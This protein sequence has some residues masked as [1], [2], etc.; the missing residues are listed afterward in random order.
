ML[1]KQSKPTILFIKS[2]SVPQGLEIGY[3]TDEVAEHANWKDLLAWIL[4][5]AFKERTVCLLEPAEGVD[6]DLSIAELAPDVKLYQFGP[7][8]WRCAFLEGLTEE[9]CRTLA[10]SEAFFLNPIW[11]TSLG[12][13]D[14][15]R[16]KVLLKAKTQSP[17]FHPQ[18]QE[19]FLYTDP[20][21]YWLYWLNPHLSPLIILEGLQ[22]QASRLS[23]PIIKNII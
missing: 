1:A 14:L 17:Y 11:L 18:T 20:D 21:G 3:Q 4:H 16:L 19:E 12:P 22:T 23:W 2:C 5:L 6:W 10:R 13:S 7:F 15:T 9:A 8:V